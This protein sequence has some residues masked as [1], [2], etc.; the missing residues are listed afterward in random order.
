MRH[1]ELRDLAECL[2]LTTPCRT[3]DRR[4]RAAPGH[5]LTGQQRV[6]GMVVREE[7]RRIVSVEQWRRVRQWR[8]LA[9]QSE[10]RLDTAHVRV[11][12]RRPPERSV[13][14]PVES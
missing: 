10:A 2:D 3:I 14:A 11:R 4:P 7:A 9:P 8:T 12:A 1:R 6:E 5:V 13:A